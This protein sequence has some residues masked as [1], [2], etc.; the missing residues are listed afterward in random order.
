MNPNAIVLNYGNW[1]QSKD[2][3][4]PIEEMWARRQNLQG[5]FFRTAA[6]PGK[7]YVTVIKEGCRTKDCFQGNL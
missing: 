2:L 4:L 7:P 3:K 5:H 1:T 6:L